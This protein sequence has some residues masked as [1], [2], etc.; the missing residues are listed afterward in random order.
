MQGAEHHKF[1]VDK[2]YGRRAGRTAMDPVMITAMAS[3][4]FHLQRANAARTDCNAE[5][6][7]DRIPPGVVSIAE[8][9]VGTP[10]GVSTLTARTL[11]KMKY[12]MTTAKGISEEFNAHTEEEP[13][14]GLGQGATDGP[15]KW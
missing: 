7:Y 5:A 10:A 15:A 6:C 9:N 12:Y 8:T 1:L 14:Y 3:K 2:Q 13:M 11:E 4:M